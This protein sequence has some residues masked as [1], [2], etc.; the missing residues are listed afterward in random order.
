MSYILAIDQGTTSSRA[1]VFDADMRPQG[2]AQEEFA[3]HFPCS[4]WVEHA[5]EDL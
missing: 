2:S 3:Q 4:G 1:I 5:P